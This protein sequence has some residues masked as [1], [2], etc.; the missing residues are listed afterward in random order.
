MK[1]KYTGDEDEV[2]FRGV[3]FEAGKAVDLSENAP[4]A[5]KVSVLAD[6][7]EVKRGKK[8]NADKA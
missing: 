7:E 4:L 3:T 6:F 1:Y 2:T 5:Q 8:S